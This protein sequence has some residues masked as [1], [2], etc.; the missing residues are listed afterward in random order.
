MRDARGGERLKH[1]RADG[2]A[3]IFEKSRILR[4]TR[5]T[6][7]IRFRPLSTGRKFTPSAS[8][9]LSILRT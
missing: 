3:T 1:R 6:L 5:R 9:S 4:L 8:A 2:H 7:A